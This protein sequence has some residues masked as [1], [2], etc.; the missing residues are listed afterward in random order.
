MSAFTTIAET[1]AR[2]AFLNTLTTEIIHP[3]TALK[4][5]LVSD[6]HP[7]RHMGLTFQQETQDRTRKRI[8]EDIKEST[9][10][11]TEFAENTLPK[12]KRAYLKKCQEF[13]VNITLYNAVRWP[14]PLTLCHALRITAYPQFLLRV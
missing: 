13:E 6:S 3:L 7:S 2:Q 10:A 9:S 12:Y 8:K 4:A 5:S 11:H 1:Q 14:I